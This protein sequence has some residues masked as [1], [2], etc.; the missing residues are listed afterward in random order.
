MSIG[1]LFFFIIKLI[2]KHATLERE[3]ERIFVYKQKKIKRKAGQNFSFN[4]EKI[5]FFILEKFFE[6]KK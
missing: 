5:F 6:V 1:I 2:N 4:L 3:R